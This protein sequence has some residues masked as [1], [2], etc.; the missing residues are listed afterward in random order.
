[1]EEIARPALFVPESKPTVDLLLELQRAGSHLAVVVDEYGGATGICTIEDILE[2][3]VGEIED[4]YDRGPSP[5]RAEGPGL[6]RVLART[7]IAQVN[8]A[9]K[10][11]LPEGEDYET[12]AGLLLDRLKRIPHEGESVRF[13]GVTVTVVTASERAIEEVRIRVGRRR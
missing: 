12:L 5:I 8:L 2:E 11:A 10:I 1:M 9:L 7:P 6:W 13:E 3:I 4:E